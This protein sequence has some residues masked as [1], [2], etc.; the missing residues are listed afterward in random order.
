MVIQ[1]FMMI[2]MLGFMNNEWLQ[3]RLSIRFYEPSTGVWENSC[4]TASSILQNHAWTL[5]QRRIK[6]NFMD[7][8]FLTS[9]RNLNKIWFLNTKS[10]LIRN[11]FCRCGVRFELIREKGW[12]IEAA[13]CP[14]NSH[15]VLWAN[16]VQCFAK[17]FIL[18]VHQK[19]C[20]ITATPSQSMI[21]EIL[22]LS[23][24]KF[25]CECLLNFCA[26][27]LK[28]YSLDKTLSTFYFTHFTSL[29]FSRIS[30][31]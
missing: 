22:K 29:Q 24:F 31:S 18:W 13:E 12:Y 21:W 1:I 3:N 27:K 6:M 25:F 26:T 7:C 23:T 8:D 30:S 17:Y 20:R 2:C 19:R 10:V 9:V 4:K 28:S 15:F 11:L 5:V 14:L 16:M